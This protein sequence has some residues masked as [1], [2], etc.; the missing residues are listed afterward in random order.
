MLIVDDGPIG[1]RASV[2]GAV[3]QQ[4]QGVLVVDAAIVDQIGRLAG[5]MTARKSLKSA[6]FAKRQRLCT[7]SRP[8]KIARLFL[9]QTLLASFDRSCEAVPPNLGKDFA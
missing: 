1:Y 3:D 5:S 6:N 4:V 2:V 7:F 9:L 8:V